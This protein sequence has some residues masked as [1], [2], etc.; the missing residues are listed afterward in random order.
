MP[1]QIGV[2]PDYSIVIPAHDEEELLPATLASVRAA[3]SALPGWQGEIV[4]TDNDSQ[5]RTAEIARDAGAEVVHEEHRQIARARNVG[6]QHARG[7][8]LIFVD[9]D[10]TISPTLLQRTLET[11]SVYQIMAG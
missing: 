11:H 1:I 3:M 4:V 2:P 7:R 6:G 8:F 10:T 9:A 5:D